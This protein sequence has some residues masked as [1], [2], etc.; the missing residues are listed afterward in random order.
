M[1]HKNKLPKHM[2]G[3]PSVLLD[4]Y[5][6]IVRSMPIHY[7]RQMENTALRHQMLRNMER[8]NAHLERQRVQGHLHNM[9]AGIMRLACLNHIGSLDA[10]IHHLASETVTTK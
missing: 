3:R 10:K 6:R 5:H 1:P 8:Y 7:E 4:K 2:K 9:P